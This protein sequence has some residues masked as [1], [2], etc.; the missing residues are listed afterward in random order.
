[1]FHKY[2]SGYHTDQSCDGKKKV[3]QRRQKDAYQ[4]DYIMWLTIDISDR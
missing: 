1:M 2:S 4:Y 3:K